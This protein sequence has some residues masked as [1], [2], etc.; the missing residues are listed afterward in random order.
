M[1]RTS[2]SRY[3][4]N[5]T[6]AVELGELLKRPQRE[7]SGGARAVV[8][9]EPPSEKSVRV[10]PAKPATCALLSASFRLRYIT[11]AAVVCLL[12]LALIVLLTLRS[13]PRCTQAPGAPLDSSRPLPLRFLPLLLS[14][15]V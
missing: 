10:Q 14:P 13:P 9:V 5:G 4:G 15:P 6:S 8:D 12:V 3:N 1:E 11:A 2:P 7:C